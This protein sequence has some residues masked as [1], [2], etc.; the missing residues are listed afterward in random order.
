MRHLNRLCQGANDPAGSHHICS[1]L[2]TPFAASQTTEP[3]AS[4]PSPPRAPAARSQAPPPNL[5]EPFPGPFVGEAIPPPAPLFPPPPPA[6]GALASLRALWPL[7]RSKQGGTGVGRSA[8]ADGSTKGGGAAVE[9]GG[10]VGGYAELDSKG[11]KQQG[12]YADSQS[13]GLGR[14]FGRRRLQW[15]GAAAWDGPGVGAA[16][17]NGGGA[18]TTAAAARSPAGRG[19]R[20]WRGK[21]GLTHDAIGELRCIAQLVDAGVLR[22]V[23]DPRDG[24]LPA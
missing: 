20:L 23:P 14:W 11:A 4:E 19:L 7:G 18:A 6:T 16:T 21:N 1:P 9:G 8:G 3:C 24:A 5:W 15:A 10:G 12:R 13:A 22:A 17:E 2:V